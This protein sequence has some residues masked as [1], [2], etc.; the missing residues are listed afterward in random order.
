MSNRSASASIDVTENQ[1]TAITHIFADA[2][3][4]LCEDGVMTPFSVLC[5]SDGFSVLEHTGE[6]ERAVYESVARA[7][8][9]E[10]PE[11][12]AFGYDG[13]VRM[14]DGPHDAIVCE[15]ARRGEPR[16]H[17]IACLYTEAQG[18]FEFD[19]AL[20]DAGEAPVLY[21]HG[22]RSIVSGLALLDEQGNA[23]E[24]AAEDLGSSDDGEEKS[25]TA[26]TEEGE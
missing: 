10:M 24:A 7:V 5:A 18:S 13:F 6:D 3:R 8:A 1:K 9:Q 25:S 2:R 23:P 17:V 15:T 22:T 26:D 11:A 14:A 4:C 16:A 19:D 12:Y 21:P 20:A